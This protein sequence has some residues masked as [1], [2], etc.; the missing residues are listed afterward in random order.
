MTSKLPVHKC[1]VWELGLLGKHANHEPHD[2]WYTSR[3]GGHQ[4]MPDWKPDH[5][6]WDTDEGDAKQWHCPGNLPK[7]RLT[8]LRGVAGSGKSTWAA[9]QLFRS[10]RAIEIVSVDD[11]KL[12]LC[13]DMLTIDHERVMLWMDSIIT[14][15]LKAGKDVIVDEANIDW[16]NVQRI[17][18]LA[19][20]LDV[21]V[22]IKVFD[23]DFRTCISRNF[24]RAISGGR[25]V[26]E[27][28][29]ESQW[30]RFQKTKDWTLDSSSKQGD[31]NW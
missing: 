10:D 12:M 22:V 14:G 15:L 1:L 4:Q 29:I 6:D 19:D 21:E 31:G 27:K 17:A 5:K 8:I 26:P 30:N 13:G 18:K 25:D 23:V 3:G 28:I 20:G 7:Q 11:I 16:R 9:E 24:H 2:W